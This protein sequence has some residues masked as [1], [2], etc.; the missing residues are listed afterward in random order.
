MMASKETWSSPELRRRLPTRRPSVTCQIEWQGQAFT[1]TI[2]MDPITG[3]PLE[4]FAGEAKGQMLATIG[5]ACVALSLAMQYGAPVAELAKSMGQVPEW[6]LRDGEMAATVRPA[7][8]IGAVVAA[9]LQL[10]E[11]NERGEG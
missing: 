8:P 3:Q 7:S 10:G 4:V 9:I 5:D 6:V 11:N 2:G 1:V